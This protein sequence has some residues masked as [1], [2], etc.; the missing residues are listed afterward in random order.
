M[1]KDMD[2]RQIGELNE[3]MF[4]HAIDY[5][6]GRVITDVCER[7]T[8]EK[9]RTLLIQIDVELV[10]RDTLRIDARV[11]GKVPPQIASPT[12]AKIVRKGKAIKAQFRDDNAENVYQQTIHDA[13]RTD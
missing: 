2:H 11:Q 10:D 7:G 5:E 8:D 4:G 9:K 3:G 6:L 1:L 12:S 13:P